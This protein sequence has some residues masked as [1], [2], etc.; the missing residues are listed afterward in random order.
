MD[1]LKY[2]YEEPASLEV[3]TPELDP[4]ARRQDGPTLSLEALLRAPRYYRAYWAGSNL[5]DDRVGL[6][7]I[8]HPAA[9]VEPLL[10]L[11]GEIPWWHAAPPR[12]VEPVAPDER[13]RILTEP[14]AGTVLVLSDKAPS[15]D[16]VW[17]L[18]S[19]PR[20]QTLPVL[21]R[22]LDVCEAVAFSEPAHHGFDWSFFSKTPLR[23]R[24]TAAFQRQT[25]PDVRRF[26]VP[27]QRARSE[28]KFY[29]ERW[30]LD[31]LPDYIQEV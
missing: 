2:F 18:V 23:D 8:R 17:A 13:A 26:V 7:A 31:Q 29:F 4:D 30:M 9:F 14:S 28:Q 19:E 20:R 10:H 5:A 21:R 22:V 3:L 16:K 24:F 27:F 15:A 1:I 11:F 12:A 25:Y 6:T